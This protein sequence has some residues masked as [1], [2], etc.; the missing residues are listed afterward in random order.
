MSQGDFAEALG[1]TQGA[2]SHIEVGRCAPS[3]DLALL[4]E[5]QT[6]IAIKELL[7]WFKANKAA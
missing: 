6:G 3:G 1:V 5:E 4:I 2:I 7:S